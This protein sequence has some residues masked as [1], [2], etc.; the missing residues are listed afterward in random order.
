MTLIT[1]IS[2]PDPAGGFPK[3]AMFSVWEVMEMMR[4]KTFTIGTVLDVPSAK[5][6][7]LREMGFK[8]EGLFVI[9]DGERRQKA[10]KFK[11]EL[12]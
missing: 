4:F 12:M 11:G 2:D 7:R 6:T 5:N 1:L 10:E 9:C 3:G 8:E